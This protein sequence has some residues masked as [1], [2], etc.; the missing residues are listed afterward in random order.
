MFVKSQHALQVYN[1][2][3]RLQ[4]RKVKTFNQ[5]YDASDRRSIDFQLRA[6]QHPTKSLRLVLCQSGWWLQTRTRNSVKMPYAFT[7]RQDYGDNFRVFVYNW[8]KAW[9]TY[10]SAVLCFLHHS[11]C[12]TH[13]YNSVQLI[14]IKQLRAKR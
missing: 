11:C 13:L 10:S 8:S 5:N 9:T 7:T 12:E 1:I 2:K 6:H 4:I 14:W 3:N